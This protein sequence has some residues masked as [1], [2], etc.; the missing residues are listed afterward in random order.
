M[1]KHIQLIIAEPCHEDWDKMTDTDKGKFCVSCKKQVVDFT[2]MTD[3]QLAVFFKKPVG[4]STCGRFFSDQLEKQIPIPRK[5]IPWLTYFFQFML[6]LFLTSLK[7]NA[8][9]RKVSVKIIQEDKPSQINNCNLI[10]LGSYS[11]SEILPDQKTKI[12]GKVFNE[13]GKPIP[14]ASIDKGLGGTIA[15]SSG[16]FSIELI[17]DPKGVKLVVSCV[18]YEPMEVTVK[19]NQI[20]K[21]E[22]IIVR[23]KGKELKAVTVSA[24]WTTLSPNMVVGAMT[25]IHRS[26][27][28]RKK[29]NPVYFSSF[30][31]YSNPVRANSPIFIKPEKTELGSYIIQLFSLSGQMIKQEI[32]NIEKGMGAT[33]FAIPAIMPGTYVVTLLNKKT[34]KKYSEKLIVQ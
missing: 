29:I 6:P 16:A 4:G 28:V 17:P 7:L 23:L 8:Q 13:D 26:R 14:F 33:S 31:I 12:K 11:S 21:K 2:G 25:V 27:I 20:I 22:E 32:I 24:G 30:K 9:K 34:G 15:D 1:P 10:M 18:G 19:D 3:S 5:R